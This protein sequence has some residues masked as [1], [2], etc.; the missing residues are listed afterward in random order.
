MQS[1]KETERAHLLS[2][3]GDL[4]YL[5]SFSS[6]SIKPLLESRA[7]YQKEKKNPFLRTEGLTLAHPQGKFCWLD[8]HAPLS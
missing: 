5:I 2:E 4:N 1:Q 8:T 6:L 7:L 3:F